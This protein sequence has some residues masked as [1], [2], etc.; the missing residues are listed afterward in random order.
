[1]KKYSGQTLDVKLLL[2]GQPLANQLVY[3][4]HVIKGH[5]HSHDDHGHHHE[6]NHDHD[7]NDGHTHTSG[8]QLR[9]NDQGIV[10]MDLPEDGIYFLRTIYIEKINEG[11]LTHESK[12]STLTFEVTHQH[13]AH[14]HTHDHDHE[15]HHEEE[16]PTWVFVVVSAAIIGLLFMFFRKKD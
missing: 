2:G 6:H 15:H 12:W 9:T 16:L 7:H 5:S 11:D 4:D 8:Q 1:M 13:G 10:T 3:A 14:T